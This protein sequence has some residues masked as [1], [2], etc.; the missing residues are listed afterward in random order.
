MASVTYEAPGLPIATVTQE[1]SVLSVTITGIEGLA[2]TREPNDEEELAGITSLSP[3][4]AST[5]HGAAALVDM[6]QRAVSSAVYSTAPVPAP[7]DVM[8]RM[9]TIA[10]VNG[11]LRELGYDV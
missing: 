1:G 4:S 10:A 5:P 6:A 9:K 11:A 8:V 2:P 7:A 3:P